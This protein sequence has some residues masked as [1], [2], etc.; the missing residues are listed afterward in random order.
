MYWIKWS[1]EEARIILRV[2]SMLQSLKSLMV[3]SFAVSWISGFASSWKWLS[4][5]QRVGLAVS[6]SELTWSL[7]AE[8]LK[9]HGAEVKLMK[10]A[11]PRGTYS[12]CRQNDMHSNV[13]S[14]QLGEAHIR[15]Y[16]EVYAKHLTHIFWIWKFLI[17]FA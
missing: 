14:R 2:F 11:L 7:I 5:S 12:K 4:M 8:W 10:Y 16:I 1:A 13:R 3:N 17:Y 15:I 6:K 9:N